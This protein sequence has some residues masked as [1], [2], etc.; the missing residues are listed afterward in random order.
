MHKDFK[1]INEVILKEKA[2]EKIRKVVEEYDITDNFEQVF[3]ELGKV[4]KA[5]RV[6]NG[7]LFLRVE[8]SV[9]RSELNLKKNLIVEKLNKHYSKKVL[10]TIKF[11]A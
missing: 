11:I 8:N 7:I 5:V 6:E 10:K 9:W 3:P 2:F 4:A 1:S